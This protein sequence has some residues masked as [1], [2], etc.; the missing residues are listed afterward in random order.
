MT[1]EQVLALLVAIAKVQGNNEPTEWAATVLAAYEVSQAPAP[2]APASVPL[3][4]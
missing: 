1:N 3:S 4:Q 2:Q